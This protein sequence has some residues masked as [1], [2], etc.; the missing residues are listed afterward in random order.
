MEN[1]KQVFEIL[2]KNFEVL[3]ENQR[4]IKQSLESA[5]KTRKYLLW[6]AIATVVMLAIPVIGVIIVIP[7]FFSS[8]ASL[9]GLINFSKEFLDN[10]LGLISGIIQ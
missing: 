8:Y 2:K 3:E 1:E 6:M 10:L 4:L 5:K 9:M 7:M